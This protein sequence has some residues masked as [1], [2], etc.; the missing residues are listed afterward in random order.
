MFSLSLFILSPIL[1]ICDPLTPLLSVST[2]NI[3]NDPEL[4]E[5]PTPNAIL[6]PSRIPTF[7][8]SLTNDI[9]NCVVLLELE[10]K[11]NT[12]LLSPVDESAAMIVVLSLRD[13]DDLVI[14]SSPIHHYLKYI[15]LYHRSPTLV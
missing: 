2:I 9:Y 3:V 1:N 7:L 11:L 13:D 12:L 6:T 8:M 5:F 4:I 10:A 15:H 14:N